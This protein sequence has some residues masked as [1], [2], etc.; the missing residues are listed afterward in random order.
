MTPKIQKTESEWKALLAEK[1]AEPLAYQV[2]R[3]EG[4]ERAFTGKY[5]DHFKDGRYD[6]V[7]CGTPLFAS[8]TKFDAGC[9]W[10]SYWEPLNSEV[11][12]RVVDQSG[13]RL[14]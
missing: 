3:K 10:P 12:E 7:G 1:G 2:T 13:V 9:G 4:T 8:G 6:C 11:V 5:W 14:P